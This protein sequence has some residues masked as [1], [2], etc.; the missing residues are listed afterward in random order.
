MNRYEMAIA[1]AD[2]LEKNP[3]LYMFT[4]GWL[5]PFPKDPVCVLGAIGRVA[6]MR[7][8]PVYVVAQQLLGMEETEFYSAMSNVQHGHSFNW[9]KKTDRWMA[10][11]TVAAEILRRLADRSLRLPKPAQ[12]AYVDP[13]PRQMGD[14]ANRMFLSRL[15]LRLREDRFRRMHDSM[16]RLVIPE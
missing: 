4:N 1:G 10:S 13:D 2:Y 15:T 6:G 9:D 5:S 14:M 8:V 16:R 7:D 11:A 12:P 3:H